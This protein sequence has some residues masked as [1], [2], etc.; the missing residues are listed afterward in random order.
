MINFRFALFIPLILITNAAVNAQSIY[1]LNGGP[2]PSLS[3]AP[4][5]SATS[6]SANGFRYGTTRSY[7]SHRYPPAQFYGGTIVTGYPPALPKSSATY[8]RGAMAQDGV[9]YVSRAYI[10]STSRRASS[11]T[12]SSDVSSGGYPPT[13][14]GYSVLPTYWPAPAPVLP[15]PHHCTGGS[16]GF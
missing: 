14:T 16:C 9:G 2:R 6:F 8:I 5:A 3:H 1:N 7:M 13:A 15:F 12:G 4:A 10:S 11:P